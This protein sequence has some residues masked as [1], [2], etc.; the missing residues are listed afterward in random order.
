MKVKSISKNVG[1]SPIKAKIVADTVRGMNALRASGM[2]E[3]VNKG[4]SIHVKKVIDAALGDAKHNHNLNSENLVISE[5]R[6]DKG[7]QA[8]LNTKRG[9]MKGKGG[10][11]MFNRKY[12]HITVV[13]EEKDSLESNKAVKKEVKSEEVKSEE[14][15]KEVKREVKVAKKATTKKVSKTVKNKDSK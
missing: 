6:V 7:P 10:Y 1:I 8:K 15:K 14:V 4:A 3:F 12:A 5:I 2:L 9:I 13:L 11:A